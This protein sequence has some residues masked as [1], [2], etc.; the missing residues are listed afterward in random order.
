MKCSRPA[1]RPA[2][3]FAALGLAGMLALAACG[4]STSGTATGA[5]GL[6][7]AGA[8]GKAPAATGTPH[9]GTV[10]VA[11][12]PSTSAN[13]ILPIVTAADNSVFNVLSFDF[14]MYRPLYWMT[15]GV[16][17]E[18]V[19]SMSLA[20]PPKW[21]DGD[22]TATVT[23]S[24]SYKWSD[25]APVT[26][27]DVLF[28]F[29]E[30]KAALKESPANWAPYVPG[31]GIPDQ[32]A[33]VST[34]NAS[35]VVF[36]LTKAVN[37]AWFTDDQLSAIQP[38]PAQAWAKTSAGG[39]T[40]N[41]ASPAS[42]TKIY[43]FLAAQSKDLASYASNPLWHL[44]DGPYKLTSF[45]SA[46]GAFIMSPNASYGGPH[47][48]IWPT[49]QLVPFTSDDAEVNAVRAGSVDVG[50]LPLTDF[51]EIPSVEASGY[52][53]FG[54]PTFG[55][56]YIAYN[57]KDA[58]GDFDH[59]IGQ[60]YIR[61]A[62]AHLK[63]ETGY[64]KAFLGGAGGPAFGPVPSIPASQ[65][66]P[67]DATAN[68]YPFSLSTA[69][70]LLKSHG[71]NVVPGGTDTCARPGTAAA[72][73]GAGIPKGTP[74]SWTLAYTTSPASIGEE[75]QALASEAA[76]AGIK[77]HLKSSNFDFLVQNYNDPAVPKNEDK[78][79]MEDFGGFTD[80]AY[81]TTF[82][83]F[84]STGSSNL[85]GYDSPEANKLITASISSS[86]PDAVKAEA[87][88]LTAQQPGLF[89]PNPDAGG[90]GSCVIVWKKTLSGQ[91]AS[92]E[93]LTQFDLTPEFWYFTK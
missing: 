37:P 17:P 60:L 91:P 29:D 75:D 40:L 53:A 77:I 21:S 3:T 11:A 72:D 61:Q 76:K 5:V 58:T 2:V 64:I 82:G 69:V 27:K 24:G 15:N 41:F 66:A 59:I 80:A 26:A 8:Y 74:L 19:P 88:Y 48:K 39:P 18:L 38:M 79:A 90:N 42:A 33:S 22:K 16:K 83:V 32:V 67:A 52:R 93:N 10:T 30:V 71:W 92:F 57:F 14:E 65:Y 73:C 28:W 1:V 87:A 63:D 13:W 4:T 44:V 46:T 81:P 20:S 34:P 47:A 54:Y 49:L 31:F 89:Q 84:N 78:W 9:A 86:N 7:P 25:G 23:L 50:Y 6:G 45:N 85:G 36:H 35:T 56:T 70:S 51:S 55:W 62:L 43:N 12:P 68:P